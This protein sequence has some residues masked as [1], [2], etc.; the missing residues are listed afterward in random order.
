MIRA[1]ARMTCLT[2]LGIGAATALPVRAMSTESWLP[3]SMLTNSSS[4]L[5]L[6]DGDKARYGAIFAALRDQKWVDARAMIATLDDKDPIRPL[7]LSEL[8]LAKGSPRAELFELLELINKAAWL[9]KAD[10][11]SRLAEKRGATMLPTL[12][13]VQKMV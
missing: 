7:A 10:Q 9:P 4:P 8:L 6:G 13:Q 11:L 2:L 5:Q 12:P 1:A 3:A